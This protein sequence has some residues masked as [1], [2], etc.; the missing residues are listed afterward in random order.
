MEHTVLDPEIQRKSFRVGYLFYYASE[1]GRNDPFFREALKTRLNTLMADALVLAKRAKLDVLNACSIMNNALFLEEQMF[2]RGDG[3][4][5]YY[6]SNY[7]VNPI[8]G[9][10][11]E[12]NGLD[13]E[14]LSGV[15]VTM[16]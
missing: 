11:N 7:K 16:L 15:G 9:G 1:A 5:Y 4:L 8:A 14:L 12:Y 13:T 10:M 2:K 6:I 3:Q